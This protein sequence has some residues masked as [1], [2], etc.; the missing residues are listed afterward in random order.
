MNCG[1]DLSRSTRATLNDCATLLLS[2]A[3]WSHCR[4]RGERLHT[5]NLESCK[6]EKKKFPHHRFVI[7]FYMETFV[8]AP[9]GSVKTMKRRSGGF[10]EFQ[11][12]VPLHFHYVVTHFPLL[13]L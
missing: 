1:F 13:L 12:V 4:V 10:L 11:V 7:D 8:M 6:C 9:H 2:C 5:S 3:P